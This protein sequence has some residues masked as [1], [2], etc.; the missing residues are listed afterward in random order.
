MKRYPDTIET[1]QT[2]SGGTHNMYGKPEIGGGYDA[3][4]N[5]VT[6][7]EGFVKMSECRLEQKRA[8]PVQG[9]DGPALFFY[10]VAYLPRSTKNLPKEGDT[11]RISGMHG[12]VVEQISKVAN[13]AVTYGDTMITLEKARE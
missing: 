11:V 8:T 10:Y 12:N 13:V 4:G 3:A 2:T 9:N 1:L 5:P 6:D 7:I